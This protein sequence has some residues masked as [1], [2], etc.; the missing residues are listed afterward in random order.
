MRVDRDIGV[1]GNGAFLLV[2]EAPS[3][4]VF[5]DE[6]EGEEALDIP[7]LFDLCGVSRVDFLHL[8]LRANLLEEWSGDH[9]DG[10]G[11]A[12]PREK[13]VAGL[14]RIFQSCSAQIASRII[15]LG[16]RVESCFFDIRTRTPWFTWRYIR[17]DKLHVQSFACVVPHPSGTSRWWNEEENV[18]AARAFWRHQA[19]VAQHFNTCDPCHFKG[20]QPSGP[21]LSPEPRHYPCGGVS[22]GGW[23]DEAMRKH[24]E[25]ADPNKSHAWQGWDYGCVCGWQLVKDD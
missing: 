17:N 4:R 8:F 24:F 12:F 10:K 20:E 13:A 22:V 1:F 19:R 2:G 6:K 16:R 21:P 3:R 7:R 14:G 15:L 18:E 23:D 5:I 11:D 25:T 9:E